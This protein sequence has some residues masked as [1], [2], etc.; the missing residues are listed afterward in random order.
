M[1]DSI[2]VR[3]S[4]ILASPQ[5][6]WN[7]RQRCKENEIKDGKF[8]LSNEQTTKPK[9]DSTP[10]HRENVLVDIVKR[11]K[12]QHTTPISPI[13]RINP[14]PDAL[15]D[16]KPEQDSESE[17][18]SES[19][20]FDS[21]YKFEETDISENDESNDPEELKAAF[22][23]LYK[24]VYN[25]KEYYNNLVLILDELYNV[26]CLTKEERDGIEISLQKRIRII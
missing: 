17:S 7:H 3:C 15:T 20:I 2:C 9:I 22:R 8:S 13:K 23:N 11:D 4:K 14:K 6:L 24:K 21:D 12:N 10:P 25:I 26:N 18:D 5:S 19:T 1:K 16:S